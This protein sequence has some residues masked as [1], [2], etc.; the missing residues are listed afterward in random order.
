MRDDRSRTW[1]LYKVSYRTPSGARFR[2]FSFPGFRFEIHYYFLPHLMRSAMGYNENGKKGNHGYQIDVDVIDPDLLHVIPAYHG[3]IFH[4]MAWWMQNVPGR[5]K[6]NSYFRG[7][8]LI[9]VSDMDAYREA[10]HN[11]GQH[12]KNIDYPGVPYF[13]SSS[14][15][16]YNPPAN[17]TKAGA[18]GATSV[19]KSAVAQLYPTT[20]ETE[21]FYAM[22]KLSLTGTGSPMRLLHVTRLSAVRPDAHLGLWSD[23]IVR[24]PEFKDLTKR[25]AKWPGDCTHWCLPGVPDAWVDL[26][27]TNALLEPTFVQLANAPPA[28]STAGG[29][30]GSKGDGS[31]GGGEQRNP[32]QGGSGAGGGAGGTGG[33]AGGGGGGV[34]ETGDGGGVT[35]P[36]VNPPVN[37]PVKSPVKPPA[38]KT[39]VVNPPVVKPPAAKPPVVNPPVVKPPAVKPPAVTPPVVNP[40]MLKPPVKPPATKPP[41][42]TSPTTKPPV[43]SPP[44]VKSPVT[45]PPVVNPP[46]AKSPAVKPPVVKP[47]AVT[48][49][50]TKPLVKPPAVKPPVV[51]PPAAKAPTVKPPGVKPPLVRPPVTSPAP[52]TPVKA[53]VGPKT[54]GAAPT[55]P[56]P[57]LKAPAGGNPPQIVTPG[58][59]VVSP[60]LVQAPGGKIGVVGRWGAGAR[61]G[62]GGSGGGAGGGTGQ[63]GGQEQVTR[64]I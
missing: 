46:V 23:D 57:P 45:K 20:Q 54:P 31:K 12:L 50:T 58:G 17:S 61:G 5:S 59:V 34:G 14:P 39:P 52:K 43:V 42:V 21:N 48:P 44:A 32:Q 38:A 22:Q 37:P 15:K 9:D 63:S 47:P 10:M 55:V 41:A 35:P 16:H 2:G 29:K 64:S 53:P 8:K 27:Y 40:P 13:V 11:L 24:N 7:G 62:G 49:P 33:S 36:A 18:C 28:P 51:K 56:K 60:G 25:M 3:I 6:K 26:Y 1:G 30:N 19:V 4:S